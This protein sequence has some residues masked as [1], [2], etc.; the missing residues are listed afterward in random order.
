MNQRVRRPRPWGPISPSGRSTCV[1]CAV[2]SRSGSLCS[3][4]QGHAGWA[5]GSAEVHAE[6]ISWQ[7]AGR[8]LPALSATVP[9]PSTAAPVVPCPGRSG[10]SK[11]SRRP[12][13]P[14]RTGPLHRRLRNSKVRGVG[15]GRGGTLSF[16]A[17][18]RRPD[19]DS[20]GTPPPNPDQSHAASW[21]CSNGRPANC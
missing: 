19:P 20:L 12:F 10:S 3:S 21:D 15:G 9:G 17:S 5:S 7:I 18:G 11:C 8:L 4:N 6:A 14:C 2:W 1:R 16:P 13:P